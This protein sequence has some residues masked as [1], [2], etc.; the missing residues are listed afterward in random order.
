VLRILMASSEAW[1]LLKTG[2]LADVAGSLPPAL[3][4]LGHDVRLLLPAYPAALQ[5][6]AGEGIARVGGV[7]LAGLA[8]DILQ[9]CLPGTQVAVWLL[10]YP[11]MFA[12][13]GNPYLQP[14][15]RPWWDNEHRF[16]LFARAVV[17]LALD[18]VG[19]GWRPDV[20]HC[21]DWQAGLAPALLSQEPRRPA[22]V[23]TI[24]NLSYQGLFP[25]SAF[26]ALQLPESLRGYQGLEY[27]GQL[28]FIKG[29]IVYADRVNTVSPRYAREI[30]SG[31]MGCGLDGLLRHRGTRLSGILNGIDADVWNPATD[32]H[33]AQTYD[34]DHLTRKAANGE[35]LRRRMALPR[36]QQVPLIGFIGRL[37][38]QKG[39]DWLLQAID[40]LG[41]R[42]HWVVLGS[43]ERGFERALQERAQRLPQRI[44]VHIGYDETL[45]HQI[46][47]GADLFL[48]PSRFEP[49]GLNQMYSLRYGTV[50]V[51]HAVGGLADTV[52]DCTAAALAAGTANGFCFAQPGPAALLEALERALA[53][54]AD[55]ALW[56]RLQRAGMALDLSWRCSAHSYGR[57]YQRAIADRASG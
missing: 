23:F 32:P 18:R 30:Q 46:E 17:A 8:V 53:A 26:D 38:E 45:A 25:G 31:A 15:G 42:A 44:A 5:A 14:D 52:V 13:P 19:L 50:P 57:L 7:E 6:A 12:R 49:C 28:S 11:P 35:F 27:H 16:A 48:M 1:P 55:A 20:V 9:T 10:D 2:G 40:A 47:A 34:R 39:V 36:T 4:A 41:D 3:A 56:R 22:T 24:H 54:F 33:L 37:V 21:N 43:G 29:G 51:V